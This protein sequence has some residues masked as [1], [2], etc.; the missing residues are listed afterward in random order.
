MYFVMKDS[1]ENPRKNPSS[2]DIMVH[3]P[4]KKIVKFDLICMGIGSIMGMGFGAFL[5]KEI[6]G[7]VILLFLIIE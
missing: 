5:V 4:F 6:I 1:S 7:S 2:W 3:A